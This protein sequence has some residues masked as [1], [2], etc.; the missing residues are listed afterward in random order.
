MFFEVIYRSIFISKKQI[1]IGLRQEDSMVVSKETSPDNLQSSQ[2]LTPHYIG[3]RQRL[4]ER[5]LIDEGASMPDYELLELILTA[6]IPRR[7]VKELAKSLLKKFGKFSKVLHASASELS[8]CKV[9]PAAIA[10]IKVILAAM[11]KMSWQ[12]LEEHDLPLFSNFDTMIDYARAILSNLQVEEFRVIFLDGSL[13]LIREKIMQKGTVNAVAVHPREV[14]KETLDCGASSIIMLHNHP[15]GKNYP[16]KNDILTT[17]NI[18]KALSP[19]GIKLYDHIIIANES[20]FS[21]RENKFI[22]D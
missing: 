15:G 5:F 9:P 8:D 3:H 17:Q 7:D 12:T 14:V 1:S 18:L 11:R 20:Y 13:K 21:F 19:L 10:Y 16:S 4:R 6:G 2:E 22:K